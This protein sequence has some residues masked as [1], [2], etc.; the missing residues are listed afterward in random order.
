MNS[1][2][3][4][5]RLSIIPRNMNIKIITDIMNL[6]HS[7]LKEIKHKEVIKYLKL[8]VKYYL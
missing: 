2:I 4:S 6:Y 8:E 7:C 5:S 3:H 1:D